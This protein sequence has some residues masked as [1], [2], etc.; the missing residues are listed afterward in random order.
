MAI[1]IVRSAITYR[2]FLARGKN[3]FGT[4]AVLREVDDLRTGDDG[5]RQG[6]HLR[7]RCRRVGLEREPRFEAVNRE[8]NNLYFYFSKINPFPITGGIQKLK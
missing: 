6:K 2:R 8:E 5:R 3:D 7:S 4:L 1:V